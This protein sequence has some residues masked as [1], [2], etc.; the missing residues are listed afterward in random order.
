MH[1]ENNTLLELVELIENTREA[2]LTWAR[3]QKKTL[4]LLALYQISLGLAGRINSLVHSSS[5]LSFWNKIYNHIFYEG[6]LVHHF[7]YEFYQ[8]Y[9]DTLI[10]ITEK[11]FIPS[12]F[13]FQS[14]T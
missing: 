5:V 2:R 6:W 10:F 11:D 9:N 4:V 3:D 12:T 8:T 1:Q 13:H 7:T 14:L